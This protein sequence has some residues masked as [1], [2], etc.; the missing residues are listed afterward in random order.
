MKAYLVPFYLFLA[1][2]KVILIFYSS[3][4]FKNF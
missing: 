1:I 2:L 4:Q 3:Y